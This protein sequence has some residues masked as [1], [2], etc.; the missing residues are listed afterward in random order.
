MRHLVLPS[1]F[2]AVTSVAAAC[3]STPAPPPAAPGTSKTV[4]PA[5]AASVSGHVSFEGARP[6]VDAVRMAID[7]VCMQNG[8]NTTSDTV[9][10]SPDGSLQNVFVYIKDD[11]A[12]Y[13]F[14]AP[15]EKVV[16]EQRGCR[17]AP[18]VFGVRA[19]QPIEMTSADQTLHNVHAMPMKNQEFNVSAPAAGWRK[20]QVFTVPEVMVPFRCNVH[21]WMTAYIGVMAHPYFAVTG[22]DGNFSLQGFPPG[23]Y[24]LTAWHEKFGTRTQQFT[25]GPKQAQAIPFSFSATTK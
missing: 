1:L 8:D 3:G 20:T 4:D 11:F 19:G 22:P 14:D 5:T 21:A 16:L 15:T 10:I 2:V 25:V 12:G 24:T 23:S 13:T 9:L 7:P 18:H 6:A 17:Y